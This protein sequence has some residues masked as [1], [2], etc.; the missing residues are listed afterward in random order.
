MNF[1][2]PIKSQN[3][4]SGLCNQIQFILGGMVKARE[5]GLNI[6]LMEKFL[7]DI[8]NHDMV[9]P[10]SEIFDMEKMNEI[11]NKKYQIYIFDASKMNLNLQSI[12]I[13][14]NEVLYDILKDIVI[15][16]KLYISKEYIFEKYK[17]RNYVINIYLKIDDKTFNLYTNLKNGKIEKEL[18]I[19]LNYNN[20]EFEVGSIWNKEN[21]KLF[22]ELTNYIYFQKKFYIVVEEWLEKNNLKNKIYNTLHLR[23]E[24]D[25]IEHWSKQNNMD[26][27]TYKEELIKKYKYLIKKYFDN[28]IPLVLLT[29]DLNNEVIDYLK[30][31]KYKIYFRDKKKED[32]REINALYDFLIGE[33]T[34]GIYMGSLCSSFTQILFFR[35]MFKNIVVF[36]LSKIKDEELKRLNNK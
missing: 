12:K 3:I 10:F 30:K 28:K 16:S 5:E 22:E 31:K 32:G 1:I 24:D 2:Y 14:D 23:I 20:I 4:D 29:Y 35:R 36:F 6:L 19:D 17:D 25:A 8:N 9:V 26:K 27:K 13:D 18:K 15:D 21:T 7:C 33:K 11:L 34:E